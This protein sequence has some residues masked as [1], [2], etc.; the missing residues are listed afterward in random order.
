MPDVWLGSTLRSHGREHGWGVLP[1]WTL[2]P[3][4]TRCMAGE[5]SPARHA[6]NVGDVCGWGVL[7]G[8][9][10]HQGGKAREYSP[11]QPLGSSKTW[12]GS[13]PRPLG[14]SKT[15]LG[16]TPRPGPLGQARHGWGIFPGPAGEYPPAQ[17]LGSSKTW[18][19]STPRPDHLGQARHGWGVLLGLILP[20]A[21]VLIRGTFRS[22][23]L[24]G[25]QL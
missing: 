22:P 16:S 7:P 19:G 4:P 10:E 8:R 3:T 5:Y 17:P 20:L 23:Q 2:R 9:M 14:A 25:P 6:H 1:G 12:L 11:A 18:L 15:W 13:T 24:M 21:T